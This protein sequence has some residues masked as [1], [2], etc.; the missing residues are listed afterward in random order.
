MLFARDW[1]YWTFFV[2]ISNKTFER[3]KTNFTLHC[4]IIISVFFAFEWNKAKKCYLHKEFSL[5]IGK[6][7]WNKRTKLLSNIP[8]NQLSC[9]LF[10]PLQAKRDTWWFF[11]ISMKHFLEIKS[12]KK[13]NEWLRRREMERKICF[14]K[15]AKIKSNCLKNRFLLWLTAWREIVKIF[16]RYWF[17]DKT[18]IFIRFKMF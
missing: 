12:D 9:F 6:R 18:R 1:H 17:R 10:L 4:C 3:D 11:C 5:T 15:R 8:N 7:A 13:G 2:F 14:V 16:W